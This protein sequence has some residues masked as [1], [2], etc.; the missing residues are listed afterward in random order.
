M[1]PPGVQTFW[2]W[3]CVFVCSCLIVEPR[4]LRE[5]KRSMVLAGLL[6]LST[7]PYGQCGHVDGPVEMARRICRTEAKRCGSMDEHVGVVDGLRRG[8]ENVNSRAMILGR[9]AQSSQT[10]RGLQVDGSRIQCHIEKLAPVRHQ[11]Q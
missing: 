11:L 7:H 2:R 3:R 1:F 8:T 6:G 9:Q 4:G 5:E 10:C